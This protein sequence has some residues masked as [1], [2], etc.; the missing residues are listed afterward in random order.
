MLSISSTIISRAASNNSYLLNTHC[1]VPLILSLHFFFFFFLFPIN[2]YSGIYSILLSSESTQFI[3]S[4]T[5]DSFCPVYILLPHFLHFLHLLTFV[6]WQPLINPWT[7]VHLLCSL[8]HLFL[9][10]L[11]STNF[12][13]LSPH[14]ELMFPQYL[15]LLFSCQYLL[16]LLTFYSIFL[17]S[18]T[19]NSPSHLQISNLLTL[20]SAF[21]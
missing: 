19:S 13:S 15:H 8:S 12:P 9:F 17:S 20:C 2:T 14:L 18:Q 5:L 7:F 11:Q 16:T 6:S 1:L 10:S 21:L 3:S 4:L